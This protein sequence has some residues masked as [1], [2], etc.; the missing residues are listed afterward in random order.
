MKFRNT[1]SIRRIF[2]LSEI[3]MLLLPVL[4]TAVFHYSILARSVWKARRSIEAL[5]SHIIEDIQRERNNS[6]AGDALDGQFDETFLRIVERIAVPDLEGTKIILYT[7]ELDVLYPNNTQLSSIASLTV[8]CTE[9]ILNGWTSDKFAYLS[10]PKEKYILRLTEV[11]FHG[12]GSIKYIILYCKLSDDVRWTSFMTV[13][14]LTVS[15]VIVLLAYL[16]LSRSIKRTEELSEHLIGE[17]RRIG[18]G[19]YTGIEGTY[20]I[21][22]LDDI[23]MA[24]NRLSDMLQHSKKQRVRF[25]Q[26]IS[27]DMRTHLM[28]ITSY[29]Q[30]LETGIAAPAEAGSHIMRE[31]E[32]LT[33]IVDNDLTFSTLEDPLLH[34]TLTSVPVL[35]LVQN[36]IDRFAFQGKQK[37][38]SIRLEGDGSE[39]FAAGDEILIEKILD[40]LLSNALRYAKNEIVISVYGRDDKVTLT[41]A[42][43][44]A[45][46]SETDLSHLFERYYKG[47]DGQHGIGL[48]IARTAAER[49]GG[50]LTAENKAAGGA[51]FTLTLPAAGLTKSF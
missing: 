45:G 20:P 23:R 30:G 16:F 25:L 22:E 7:P 15:A 6:T 48:T 3:L 13:S 42:D 29:A 17:I 24:V 14:V 11:P 50:A 18:G 1:H 51:L 19:D 44:G 4:I 35:E 21:R 49:M 12:A 41:V 39:P 2:L 28:T 46:L 26:S 10:V 47:K 43:D 34:V 27:H 9:M 37:A 8:H 36:S 31:G 33:E 32:R 38:I 5:D 40:N